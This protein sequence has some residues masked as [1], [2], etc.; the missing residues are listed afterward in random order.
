MHCFQGAGE[1]MVQDMTGRFSSLRIISLVCGVLFLHCGPALLAEGPSSAA[2]SGYDAYVSAVE[3]RLDR[4][5]RSRVDFLVGSA[6]AES[7]LHNGE[8]VLE[9]L[10]VD[11]GMSLPGALL[12]DWRGSAFVAGATAA[13]F[14]QLLKD[15]GSYSQRFAPQVLQARVVAGDGDAMQAWMRVSQRHVISV[16]LDSTYDVSFGRLD[17]QHGYSRSQS[18]KIAEIE[19]AGTKREH[20]LSVTEEHGF[21]WRLNSYWSYEERDGGLYVQIE[22]VSLTRSIPTGLGWAMRPFVESVPRDSL[23]FTLRSVYK[24]LGK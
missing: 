6:S 23:E 16:V 4:Q 15:F 2:V 14:E 5:H 24:S 20:A 21:L 17:A 11:G 12:H 9:R 18:T 1:S 10:S 22:T 3:A 8:P 7:G 19:S 13:E